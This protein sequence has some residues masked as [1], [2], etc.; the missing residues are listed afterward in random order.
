MA[1]V[2]AG[3]ASPPPADR[4]RSPEVPSTFAT[5]VTRA[6]PWAVGVYGVLP[7]GAG[8]GA[9]QP[10]DATA[11]APEWMVDARSARIGAG[12]L[13]S[14]D[15]LIVTGAHVVADAQQIVVRLSD[16]RVL[17]AELVGADRDLDVAL[18]RVPVVLP[19]TPPLGSS[20]AL[21]A[22]DWVLA[23]GEPYGLD[24]AVVAGI[25]GGRDRH[26]A[27]DGESLY[28]QSDLSLN[29]GNSGGPLLDLR[30]NIVAMNLRTVSGLE[31]SVGLSL[32]VPIEVVQRVAA[33]LLGSGHRPRPRLGAECEDVSPPMALA[34]GRSYATGA[35]V[36]AVERASLAERIGLQRGDIVV[37]VN[38]WPIGNSADLVRVL[39]LWDDAERI[40]VTVYRNG[41]YEHLRLARP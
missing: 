28:L 41:R 31:G 20:A 10:G 8:S 32:S 40:R 37:G 13:L 26:F 9:S 18:L 1:L 34:A 15:G 38:G 27:D 22:G 16:Q 30:G 11:G 6:L 5:A 12:F 24:R 3:C 7:A 39:L 33:E 19:A 17:R 4:G 14:A 2:L 29:P 21:R 36:S 35:L 23:I 25:V